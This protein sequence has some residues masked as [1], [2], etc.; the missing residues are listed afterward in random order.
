V[1]L[2]IYFPI[3]AHLDFTL[4]HP[5]ALEHTVKSSNSDFTL[6]HTDFTLSHNW[7]YIVVTDL[8]LEQIS[9]VAH[10]LTMVAQLI[11]H[12]RTLIFYIVAIIPFYIVAHWFY[13]EDTLAL[14][15]TDFTLSPI[16]LSYT[17]FT[18][19]QYLHFT[20]SHCLA[21][22]Q[23]ILHCRNDL[24]ILHCRTLWF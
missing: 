9:I 16:S 6:S 3:V 23:F 19:S 11:L 1:C 10:R 20:L 4:S 18:L 7:F 22:G 17:D 13:I 12:C 24:P 21:V 15:Y 2:T 8:A 5:F 14:S